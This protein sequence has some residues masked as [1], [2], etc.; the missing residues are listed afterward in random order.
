[1]RNSDEEEKVD[2]VHGPWF[3]VSLSRRGNEAKYSLTPSRLSSDKGGLA[4]FEEFFSRGLMSEIALLWRLL[5]LMSTQHAF[6]KTYNGGQDLT[7]GLF[8][9]PMQ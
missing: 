1:M 6:T 4:N 8:D 5:A 2:T 9:Q 3:I 7:K